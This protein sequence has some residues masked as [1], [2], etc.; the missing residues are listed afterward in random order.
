MNICTIIAKNYVAHARVLAKSFRRHHPDGSCAVL[1]VDD[2]EGFLDP[3]EEPFELI[4]IE[5]I[6]L[7]DVEKMAASYD[8]TEFSTAVKPWLLR[9]LLEREGVEAITYLDP[10]ILIA[11][12]IVEIE[13]LA[14]KHEIVLTPHFTSPLPRDGGK[15]AEEDILIAGAYNLGFISLAAGSTAAELLDWWSERLESDCVVDPGGGLFVDQRWIDLVPGIW[16]GVHVLRDPGFNVAYWNLPTREFEISGDGYL[17]DGRPLRFF[18]FSGFDPLRPKSLS[19]HQDRI[20]V[21][22][23]RALTRICE[24][25]AE[26]LL[27]SGQQE[28]RFW[29][30]GWDSLPNGAKLDAPARRVYREAAEAGEV[31]ESIFTR[32]GADRFVSHLGEVPPEACVSRYAEALWDLRVDLRAAFP[33]LEGRDAVAFNRWLIANADS[34]GIS[35]ELVPAPESIWA[36]SSNGTP[37]PGKL[38]VNLAGYLSSE[39]GVGE[40]ARQLGKALAAGGLESAEVDVPVEESRFSE[41]FAEI[42]RE[43]HPFDV[44][45]VCVNADMLP[46][47]AR[48]MPRS[49]FQRRHTAGL[50]FWEV[51][52]FPERWRDSFKFLDE[53]WTASE[54]VAD[55]VRPLAPVPVSTIRIPVTP[56]EPAEIDREALSMPDGFCFLFI[57]D[58]RSVFRR[59]NPLGAIEAFRKA[60]EPGEGASLL[61]KS[62]GGERWPEESAALAAAAAEHPDVH[63]LD[64]V[65]PAEEKNAMIA[66]C[67]CYLS[68]H[69]SEGLGLTMAEAMYFGKPVIATGYS[70]NLD[71][72]TEETGYLVDYELEP[73]GEDAGPYPSGARWAEPRLDHAVE[74]MRR[75]FENQEEARRK[76]R[77][78]ASAIRTSHSPEAAGA[79]LE[80]R[81]VELHRRHA[82]GAAGGAAQGP[83]VV[84]I[85]GDPHT[86]RLLL[87][88]LLEFDQAPPRRGSGRIRR[89]FKQLYMRALRPYAAHQRRID[90]SI[91]DTLDQLSFEL[92]ALERRAASVNALRDQISALDQDLRALD[93]D[94]RGA[95]AVQAEEIAELTDAVDRLGP[96][97]PS[98]HG[99]KNGSSAGGDQRRNE[100]KPRKRGRASA[101]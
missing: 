6:G 80:E 50:W 25:Y 62:V 42:D 89:F 88:H 66:A 91:R 85:Y 16:P 81:L 60:F 70:G 2:Y 3:A 45:L 58:F 92:A 21:R 34:L 63:L 87:Q 7:P 73:I 86:G 44:N 82:I 33:N 8:V 57:F 24:E 11:D 61:I 95:C 100:A 19:K 4:A 29:S 65:L 83:A 75:V 98:S 74:I 18:H 76:G 41:A 13:E 23:N 22:A 28:A 84:P 59:K 99:E 38:G 39:L 47:V 101:K 40:A 43:D 64:D 94:V 79:L 51:E 49:F 68:L 55:A 30:Y 46:A 17:V 93:G 36:S 9:H 14:L 67:D 77:R 37:F 72:M 56:E 97:A 31:E 78:A 15:P 71:F 48:E 52:Q 69:R 27:E 53:V 32:G 26:L 96:R 90:L 1:V 10:D 54:F 12:S 5:D 20:D 35:P